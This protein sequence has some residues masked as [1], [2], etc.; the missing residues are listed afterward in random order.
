[1]KHRYVQDRPRCRLFSS[2][3]PGCQ[4][5][6]RKEAATFPLKKLP[7][8]AVFQRFGPSAIQSFLSRVA[9]LGNWVVTDVASDLKAPAD[10]AARPNACPKCLSGRGAAA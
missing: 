8:T 10:Q 2:W 9:D 5:A 4:V 3:V 1:M 6:G 7:N